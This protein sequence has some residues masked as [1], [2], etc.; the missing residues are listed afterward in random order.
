MI[1]CVTLYIKLRFPR[2][3]TSSI[4]GSSQSAPI[5]MFSL[6]IHSVDASHPLFGLADRSSV[7]TGTTAS[8]SNPNFDLN[9]RRGVIHL[10]RSV[11][12]QPTTSLPKPTCCST[13]LFVVAVPNYLSSDD[14]LRFC[15]SYVEH[16][17]E[18]VI[19]R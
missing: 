17:S 14:F 8:S 9:E 2:G 10:F 13:I 7:F 19:I 18:L 15:G 1:Y 6:K 11:S 5:L 12:R 3:R 4:S 16:I